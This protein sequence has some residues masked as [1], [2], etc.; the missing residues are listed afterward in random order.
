MMKWMT[1]CA[2]LSLASCQTTQVNSFCQVYN[3][4]ITQKG[5]GT[6]SASPS[7]KRKLLANELTYRQL[8]MK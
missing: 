5:D 6:I 2:V 8:C 3:Q 7:V 4:V 1:L